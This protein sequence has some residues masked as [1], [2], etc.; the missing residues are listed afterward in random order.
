MMIPLSVTVI[1]LVDSMCFQFL[2]II[3]P[4]ILGFYISFIINYKRTD[5]KK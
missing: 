5:E 1:S 2:F 4:Y 3:Q